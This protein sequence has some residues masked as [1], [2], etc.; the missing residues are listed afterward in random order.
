MKMVLIKNVMRCNV[1]TI[2][3]IILEL[4]R[5]ASVSSLEIENQLM[6]QGALLMLIMRKL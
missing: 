5:M 2:W 1:P 6:T 4:A 3:I